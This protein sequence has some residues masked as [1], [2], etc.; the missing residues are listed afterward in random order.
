MARGSRMARAL[1]PAAPVSHSAPYLVPR[2]S[3]RPRLRTSFFRSIVRGET[4]YASIQGPSFSASSY[5]RCRRLLA[6]PRAPV[7]GAVADGARYAAGLAGCAA[8][9]GSGG[10]DPDEARSFTS[11]A[12]EFSST[13]SLALSRAMLR[14]ATSSSPLSDSISPRISSSALVIGR[15]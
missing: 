7:G 1:P 12:K 13:L 4:R 6:P 8:R 11:L 9:Y 3:S 15:L 10:L 2:S 14:L 5:K